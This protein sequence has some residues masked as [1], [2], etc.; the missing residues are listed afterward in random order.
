MVIAS[1][2][3]FTFRCA[4]MTSV[5]CKYVRRLLHTHT[6]KLQTLKWQPCGVC[7]L[8]Y[9]SVRDKCDKAQFTLFHISAL[10][11]VWQQRTVNPAGERQR[12]WEMEN[13]GKKALS[14]LGIMAALRNTE[15]HWHLQMTEPGPFRPI[16][17]SCEFVMRKVHDLSAGDLR[18]FIRNI[19][20]CVIW[21]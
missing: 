1:C 3:V 18:D 8:C 20:K 11:A 17:M 13:V 7:H 2:V 19:V 10:R 14:A 21:D 16:A 12:S 4:I 6:N 5:H 9:M 15:T